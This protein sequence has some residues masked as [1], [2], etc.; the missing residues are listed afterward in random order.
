MSS[1]AFDTRSQGPPHDGNYNTLSPTFGADGGCNNG[2]VCEHR[3]RQTFNMV[4]FKN[5]VE[6]AAVSHWWDNGDNQ[7]AFSR[8][9]GF[10]IFNGQYRVDFNQVLQT[11]LPAGVY[12]DLATGSKYLNNCTGTSVTVNADGTASFSLSSEA[13]EGYL[14]ISVDAKL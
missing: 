2:W 10:I 7:I 14:A 5:T 9:R 6:G 12:C 11:G 1:F 8:N 4:A 13:A 3:W